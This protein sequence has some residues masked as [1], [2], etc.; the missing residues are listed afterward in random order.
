MT[1]SRKT[2]LA[3]F[4]YGSRK[5]HKKLRTISKDKNL[6]KNLGGPFVNTET[7]NAQSEKINI[8]NTYII[9][10]NKDFFSE[11]GIKFFSLT[12]LQVKYCVH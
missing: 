1:Y 9:I 12:N 7:S 5:F 2:Q 6:S 11:T 4:T 8:I 10:R 3:K